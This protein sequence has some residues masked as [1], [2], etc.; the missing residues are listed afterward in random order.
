MLA[1]AV[2]AWKMAWEA[3]FGLLLLYGL[4]AANKGS[5][6]SKE[7]RLTWLLAFPAGVFIYRYRWLLGGREFFEL[8]VSFLVVV[9][10]PAL[11]LAA[12]GS[13]FKRCLR[14]LIGAAGFLLPQVAVWNMARWPFTFTPTSAGTAISTQVLGEIAGVLVGIGLAFAGLWALASAHRLRLLVGLVLPDGSNLSAGPNGGN[15]PG[16]E[17]APFLTG[18]TGALLGVSGLAAYWL[19]HLV[20][21]AQVLFTGGYLSLSPA[22]FRVLVPLVNLLPRFPDLLLLTGSLMALVAVMPSRHATALAAEPGWR[23]PLRR[24][25]LALNRAWHR[26]ALAA[27][28]LMAA[29]V[30]LIAVNQALDGRK[31]E[32]SPAVPVAAKGSEVRIPLTELADGRL[33]RYAYTAAGG[34]KVRFI[35][36]NKGGNL[37]GTGL[38]YCDYCG[39]T[40]YVERGD[41]VICVNCDVVINRVT[42]GF[43][44]GCNPVPLPSRV[45]GEEL[46]IQAA[47]LEKEKDKFAE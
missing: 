19:K 18:I 27:V 20:V 16:H 6:S 7:F 46:V 40:G 9:T 31:L 5:F 36:L 47:D 4:V 17:A 13:K 30:S 15:L 22:A 11:L 33:H 24:K 34:T 43:P 32:I 42:I 10:L 44:G 2:L 35:V 23:A 25:F 3:G 39:I 8:L 26:Q 29:A 12:R 38:D 1:N 45:G 14:W 41:K 28:V 21:A 37:Y